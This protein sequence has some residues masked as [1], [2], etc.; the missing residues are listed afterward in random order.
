MKKKI[1]QILI[2]LLILAAVAATVYFLPLKA[3]VILC[4]ILQ[5]LTIGQVHLRTTSIN[6]PDKPADHEQAH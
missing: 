2:A 3:W 5:L 4:V 6:H 1:K